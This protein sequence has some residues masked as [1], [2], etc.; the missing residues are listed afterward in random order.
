MVYLGKASTDNPTERGQSNW[1]TYNILGVAF[2]YRPWSTSSTGRS[3]SRI[4]ARRGLGPVAHGEP[5][6]RTHHLD[7][8]LEQRG[9]WVGVSAT[10]NF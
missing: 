8:R 4:S 7:S 2:D 5:S 6:V 10:F 1:V 3:V 9:N